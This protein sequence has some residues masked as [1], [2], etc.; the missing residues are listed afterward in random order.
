MVFGRYSRL[1]TALAVLL[2]INSLA[3]AWIYYQF[4]AWVTLINL[5]ILWLILLGVLLYQLRRVN[6]DLARFFQAVGD[7]DSTIGYNTATG[8][9]LFKDLYEK[10]NKVIQEFSRIRSEK[11]QEYNFFS[12]IFNHADIGLMAYDERGD[13]QMINRAAKR[14][15]GVTGLSH[16][17][18]T[19]MPEISG[20]G[21]LSKISPGERAL[22]KIQRNEDTI[23]LSVRSRQIIMPGREFTLLSLQN[24]R[25]E[26]EMN[27]VESWQKLIRVFI[28]EIMNSVSPITFTAAGIIQMLENSG[29]EET[30]NNRD[31]TAN[32]LS[33]LYAIRK[34]SK[35][36]SAFM[37]SYRQ[38]TGI[39]TPD[40]TWV[41]VG[42]LFDLIQRLM[43][44]ELSKKGIDFRMRF[45]PRDIKVW[46][47]EKLTEQVL[48]N[49]LRN[50]VDALAGSVKPTI[51]MTCVSQQNHVVIA[52]NDNGTGMDA[53]TLENIFVPF[54]TTKT[55]GSG[56]GLSISRQ[57]MNLHKGSITVQSQPGSTTFQLSFPIPV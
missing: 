13:V 31:L 28:H 26:L 36:M 6:R 18:S 55:E 32:I 56:I 23:Q 48:I 19:G 5:S 57:I 24:I 21:S 10:M 29:S 27:E 16:I 14:L 41:S 43:D 22:L 39:P 49:L 3:I 37:D 51:I 2:A 8:D 45:A 4:Q 34:R 12:A 46:A 20:I 40:F 50:A 44:D 42:N 17:D 9:P 30:V 38:L 11:E 33:G 52:V 53:H 1:L 35:G 25:Q 7:Q 15:L 54:F 47:D